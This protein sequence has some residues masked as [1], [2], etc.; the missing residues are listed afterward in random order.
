MAKKKLSL[1]KQANIYVNEIDDAI[2]RDTYTNADVILS[3]RERKGYLKQ[4]HTKICE[5]LDIRSADDSKYFDYEVYKN[6]VQAKLRLRVE[7]KQAA[8]AK[9]QQ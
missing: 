5:V 8:E 4:C 7:R 6:M 1:L 9:K 3:N 2:E